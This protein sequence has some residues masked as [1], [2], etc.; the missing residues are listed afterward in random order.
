M[1]ER[2]PFGVQLEAFVVMWGRPPV[3]PIADYGRVEPLRMRCVHT[4]LV[5]ASGVRCELHAR[6]P[7]LPQEHTPF[8]I[9]RFAVYRIMDVPRPVIHVDTQ[10]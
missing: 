6:S 8:G 10:R 7:M 9:G 1:H 3:E 4:Q 5:R 2:Q